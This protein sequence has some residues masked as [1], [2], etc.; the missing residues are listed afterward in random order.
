MLLPRFFYD[1]FGI[2]DALAVASI[3]SWGCMALLLALWARSIS[4]PLAAYATI[5][6]MLCL[7]PLSLMTHTIS[8]YPEMS[9]CFVIRR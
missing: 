6:A 5:G 3:C 2:F 8:S 4:T 7:G 9:L 1:H